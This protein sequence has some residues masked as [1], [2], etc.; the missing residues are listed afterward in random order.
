MLLGHEW[1]KKCTK[2]MIKSEGIGIKTTQGAGYNYI[3]S[4]TEVS[5]SG[6]KVQGLE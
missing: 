1:H 2:A 3:M 4:P 5:H 6:T